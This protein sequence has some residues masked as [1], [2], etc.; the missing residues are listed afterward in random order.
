MICAFISKKLGF[1]CQKKAGTKRATFFLF[2]FKTFV[3]FSYKVTPNLRAIPNEKHK[4]LSRQRGL[5]ILSSNGRKFWQVHTQLKV[6]GHGCIIQCLIWM[7]VDAYGWSWSPESRKEGIRLVVWRTLQ[8][9]LPLR[10]SCPKMA[11]HVWRTHF[12]EAHTPTGLA[13]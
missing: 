5:N 2:K 12:T 6:G 1:L 7:R 9:A 11:S 3:F 4:S 13:T 8:L 10:L